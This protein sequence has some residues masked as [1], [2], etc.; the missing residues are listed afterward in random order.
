M[1]KNSINESKYQQQEKLITDLAIL[2]TKKA[3]FQL[4]E[5][6]Y[7]HHS[8]DLYAD[9]Y[10]SDLI[11]TL[12]KITSKA[13]IKRIKDLE[14]KEV[15][16][17]FKEEIKV[18]YDGYSIPMTTDVVLLGKEILEVIRVVAFEYDFVHASEDL[19]IKLLAL[20]V[21]DKYL[22]SFSCNRIRL[23]II[24]P[25]LMSVSILETDL[26]DLLHDGEYR[27]LIS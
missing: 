13:L 27:I 7:S 21:I 9:E 2:K 16:T 20:G 15:K 6:E 22:C 8:V 11:E 1:G 5:D 23:T 3:I 26:E 18:Y 4:S 12:S 17:M 14:D 10:Y 25:N 24:Q 19:T